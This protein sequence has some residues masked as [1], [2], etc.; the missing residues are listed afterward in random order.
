MNSVGGLKAS[1]FDFSFLAGN[2]RPQ[3]ISTGTENFQALS[4][5]ES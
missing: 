5:N 3:P 1:V 4:L 2:H